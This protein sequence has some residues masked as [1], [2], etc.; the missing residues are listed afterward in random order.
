MASD[1]GIHGRG[2][3]AP[4]SNVVQSTRLKK[5][6][7]AKKFTVTSSSYDYNVASNNTTMFRSDNPQ[8]STYSSTRGY[9][10]GRRHFFRINSDNDFWLK[11]NA[12]TNDA[13]KIEAADCPFVC[14]VEEANNIF[15][16]SSATTTAQVQVIDT[17]E[18][19][20]GSLNN[21]YFYLYA[22]NNS[23]GVE[24][25]IGVWFNVNS[26]GTQPTDS[27]VDQWTSVAL[28]T[29][30]S[31]NTVATAL[32]AAIEAITVGGT[33]A[34]TSSVSTNHVTITHNSTFGGAQP[35]AADSATP[36]G[37][38][39]NTPSTEGAGSALAIDLFMV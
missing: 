22:N 4:G 23:T 34:F 31:A 13:I 21:K 9:D 12:V 14:Y 19:S 25:R 33:D 32:E 29:G 1:Y 16:R 36:T 15:L 11:F 6:Y 20:A 39:F 3:A 27:T 17:V 35:N 18:D 28:S 5:S 37:F 26:A 38:T 7:D 24:T 2:V 30:D 10:G 8:D